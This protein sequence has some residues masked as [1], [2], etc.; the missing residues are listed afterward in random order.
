MLSAVPDSGPQVF[1]YQV[2]FGGGERN[3]VSL[4][5]PE[6]VFQHGLHPEAVIAVLPEGA[7]SDAMTPADVRENGPFLRLLSRVIFENAERCSVTNQ[8]GVQAPI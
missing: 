3:V 1:R 7:D 4:L 6:W 8:V 5:E 2:D